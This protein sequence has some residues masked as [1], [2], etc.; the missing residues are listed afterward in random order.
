MRS[1]SPDHDSPLL[2]RR[3]RAELRARF[4]HADFRPGQRRLVLAALL[5]RDALGVLPTGAGKTVCFQLPAALLPGTAVVVSPLISLMADQVARAEAHGIPSARLTSDLEPGRVESTYRALESGHL[6]LLYVAPERFESRRFRAAL[7]RI[8]PSLLVVDEAHCISQWGNDFR[9]SYR[10][11]GRVRRILCAPTIAVTASA[12]PE[13]R[14]DIEDSLGLD[15]PVRVV[16]TFDRPNLVWCVSRVARGPSRATMVRRLIRAR[17]PGAA[18]VYCATRKGTEA[19]GAALRGWGIPAKAYHA[20]LEAPER[21]RVQEAFLDGGAPVVVA[22]SAFGMGIDRAD[23]RLVVHHDAPPSLE[24]YYQESGRAGRDGG[25][26]L[27]VLLHSRADGA[28]LRSR[29]RADHPEAA[30]VTTAH[31]AL[32]RRWGTEHIVTTEAAVVGE[33]LEASGALRG[34]GSFG[35]RLDGAVRVLLGSRAARAW[36]RL[37]P[38]PT[39]DAVLRTLERCGGISLVHLRPHGLGGSD[40]ASGRGTG[41]SRRGFDAPLGLGIAESLRRPHLARILRRSAFDRAAVVLGWAKTSGCRRA[42]ILAY[43]GEPDGP[44][45]ESGRTGCAGC[46]RCLGIRDPVQYLLGEAFADQHAPLMALG[47]RPPTR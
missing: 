4:G 36:T 13:V 18:L 10:A 21:E 27:C 15:R 42:A 11:L 26:A 12:T 8:D 7:E 23:V 38:G 2:L 30:A 16:L 37:R 46:D 20:G 43:F 44:E 5:G 22:T 19:L 29:L 33:V 45:V 40:G 3:A 25:R 9:P 47:P 24:A 17:P 31:R 32:V 1:P 28:W 6:R 35:S 41:T 14:R 39:S 34:A